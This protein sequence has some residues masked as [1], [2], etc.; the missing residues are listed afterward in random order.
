MD[1]GGLLY[2]IGEGAEKLWRRMA[3][4]IMEVVR[5]RPSQVPPGLRLTRRLVRNRFTVHEW[6]SL[7]LQLV[8]FAYL[9]GGFLL[10]VLTGDPLL[11]LVF[12][13]PFSLYLR[14]FL[15]KYRE[16]LIDSESYWAFYRGIFLLVFAGL[17]GYCVLKRIGGR[18]EYYYAF[19]GVVALM[20]ALFRHHFRHRYGRDYTYGIVEEVKNDLV[21]VFVYDDIAANV[22]PGYH[23]LPAVPDAEPGRVVKILVEERTLRSA[24]P[25]R[26]IEVYLDQ[27]SQT[28][29]E[30][31]EA[32]E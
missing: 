22:R 21:R 26:I 1:I 32:T 17:E 15:G 19:V 12:S 30:P 20:V 7:H 29:T 31:K 23:W 10:A 8:F 3:D 6:M 11:V 24:R 5:P 2:R 13:V 28:E 25:V 9:L 27:S 16:F 14:W 18:I 4:A